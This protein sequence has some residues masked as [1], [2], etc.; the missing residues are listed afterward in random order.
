MESRIILVWF[1]AL[2]SS[3]SSPYPFQNCL[4]PGCSRKSCLNSCLNA[5]SPWGALCLDCLSTTNE[6]IC[7]PVPAWHTALLTTL[8][9]WVF[10]CGQSSHRMDLNEKGAEYSPEF[11]SVY[12]LR[13][14]HGCDREQDNGPRQGVRPWKQASKCI[15]LDHGVEREVSV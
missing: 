15:K 5:F 4:H 14:T 13:F 1:F 8:P 12:N 11:C 10:S 7:D 9:S 3:L 2:V 6:F